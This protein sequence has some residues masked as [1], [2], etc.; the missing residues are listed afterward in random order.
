MDDWR[1]RGTEKN[2]TFEQYLKTHDHPLSEEARHINDTLSGLL[3]LLQPASFFLS[4]SI[5]CVKVIGIS[6]NA[7]IESFMFSK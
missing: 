6:R 4:I 1:Q 7:R 2:K 3:L 5:V